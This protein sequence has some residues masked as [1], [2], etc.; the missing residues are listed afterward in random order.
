MSAIN[1][2]GIDVSATTLSAA[3]LSARGDVLQGEFSNDATGHARLIAWA[4]R[5]GRRAQCCV[6]A[7]GLYS[8]PVALALHADKKTTVM[9]AN[10]RAI[11]SFAQALMQRAKTD[12]TDAEIIRTFGA[13]MPFTPWQPP[14]NET[15]QLQAIMRRVNQLKV[16][17][18]NVHSP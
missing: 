10:P 7:T 1:H 17:S 16:C 9:V 14:R 13:Q 11:K 3:R 12:R 2:V 15:L 5:R 6:E 18:T 4:T 8:L